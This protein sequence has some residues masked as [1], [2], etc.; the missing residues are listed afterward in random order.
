MVLNLPL[1]KVMTD[2][3]GYLWPGLKDLI[4]LLMQSY[5]H[6]LGNYHIYSHLHHLAVISPQFMTFLKMWKCPLQTVDSLNIHCVHFMTSMFSIEI[7]KSGEGT[8]WPD[9]KPALFMIVI[10]DSVI[11]WGLPVYQTGYIM[12]ILYVL[13]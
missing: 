1:V 9:L 7:V 3:Q 2:F 6:I 12:Y 11:R 8:W 13:L 5:H 4:P 10:P